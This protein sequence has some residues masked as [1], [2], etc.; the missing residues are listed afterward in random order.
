VRTEK[1]KEKEKTKAGANEVVKN[2]RR[3]Q[4]HWII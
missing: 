4:E 1:K 3:D 2:Q